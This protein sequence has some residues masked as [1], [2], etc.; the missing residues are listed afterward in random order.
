V[1]R[2]DDEKCSWTDTYYAAKDE[3]ETIYQR[4]GLEMVDHFAQDGLASLLSQKIDKW[5]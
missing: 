4:Y 2:H 1:L 5:D 3:M